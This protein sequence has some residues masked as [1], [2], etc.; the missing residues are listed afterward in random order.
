MPDIIRSF[1]L[2]HHVFVLATAAGAVP[3]C[4]SVF[5]LF[6]EQDAAL[7]FRS[8]G[9]TRHV[10]ELLCNPHASGAVYEET[11]DVARI[12]G[13]QVH[14]IVAETTCQDA[15]SRYLSVFPEAAS[16]RAP[17]WSL[18]IESAVLT[19]NSRGFGSR[20]RWQRS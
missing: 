1:L 2:Q 20:V 19:D 17:F 9:G 10:Q 12:R 16:F 6:D 11:R 8:S 13:I 3:H 14:G 18:R 7:V 5:Y 15:I 4:A